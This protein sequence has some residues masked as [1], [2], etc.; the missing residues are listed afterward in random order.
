MWAFCKAV[1]SGSRE[2]QWAFCAAALAGVARRQAAVRA[3][4]LSFWI[5]LSVRLCWRESSKWRNP[6]IGRQLNVGGTFYNL[7]TENQLS[8]SREGAANK[9]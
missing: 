6:E 5:G 8:A 9:S 2:K 3:R 1:P 7:V 4:F